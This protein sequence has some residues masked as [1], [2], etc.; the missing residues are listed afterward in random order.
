MKNSKLNKLL[1]DDTGYRSFLSQ[2]FGIAD[3]LEITKS[4]L[5]YYIS[6]MA[7]SLG[8]NRIWLSNETKRIMYFIAEND[9]LKE[10]KEGCKFIIQHELGHYHEV[11]DKNKNARD[12]FHRLLYTNSGSY[13]IDAFPE[14]EATRYAISKSNDYIEALAGFLAISGFLYKND[15]KTTI[16]FF[17]E[18]F[19]NSNITEEEK[20]K[21][22]NSISSFKLSDENYGKIL[23]KSGEYLNKLND[24]LVR[25][26]LYKV[27]DKSDK[28]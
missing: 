4:V 12:Y 8:Y 2:N 6:S 13:R 14:S 21:A 24:N 10:L 22:V 3:N 15:I 18:H 27:K 25:S 17:S 20:R 28:N 19:S 1:R 7:Y 5:P 26:F 16:D 9:R 11:K 23:N